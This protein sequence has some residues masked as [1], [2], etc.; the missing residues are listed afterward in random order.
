MWLK[1]NMEMM[2]PKPLHKGMEFSYFVQ[3][4]VVVRINVGHSKEEG[5]ILL[6]SSKPHIM[7]GQ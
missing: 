4:P 5:V 2:Q 7:N 6:M 3:Q 1:E